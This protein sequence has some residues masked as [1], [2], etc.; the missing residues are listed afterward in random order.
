MLEAIKSFFQNN[1][2]A[3]DAGDA[4]A[5]GAET[6]ESKEGK[7]ES[8]ERRI[9]VAACALLL[10]LAHA[11]DEFSDAERQHIESTIQRHFDMDSGTGDELM[12]L[13]ERER[14]ASVDL[15]QFTSLIGNNFSEGQKMVLVEAMWG[16]VYADGK[17]TGHETYLMRKISHLL[18]VKPGYMSEL[19]KR[20]EQ[21][22]TNS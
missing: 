14:R 3:G 7:P 12:A 4:G 8:G 21:K 9:E 6:E 16:L 10:E 11:D 15:F 5:T 22:R 20:V 13:A 19:R 17:V 2:A 18:G 1:I